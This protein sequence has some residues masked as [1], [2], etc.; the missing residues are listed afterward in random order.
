MCN[1]PMTYTVI[2]L[3]LPD[4]PRLQLFD[5]TDDLKMAK[6]WAEAAA[7][8]IAPGYSTCVI[9]NETDDKSVAIFNFRPK[10]AIKWQEG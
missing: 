9:L 10:T 4:L 3:G 7:E 2:F 6:R 5:K 1:R 8:A